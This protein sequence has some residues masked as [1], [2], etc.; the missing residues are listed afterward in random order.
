MFEQSSTSDLLRWTRSFG[1]VVGLVKLGSGCRQEAS[2]TM[3]IPFVL[4]A[5]SGVRPAKVECEQAPNRGSSA[6]LVQLGGT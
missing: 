4:Y 2:S 5:S 6:L 3:F 1:Q